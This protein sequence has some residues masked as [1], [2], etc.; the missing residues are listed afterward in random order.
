MR[1]A[2]LASVAVIATAVTYMWLAKSDTALKE[3]TVASAAS[4]SSASKSSN[5]SVSIRKHSVK[6]TKLH[7][8]TAILH[9]INRLLT[10]HNTN[11]CPVDNSDPRASE[12]LRRDMIVQEAQK[13]LDYSQDDDVA[14]MARKLLAYDDGYV[15]EIALKLM[16]TTDID[17]KNLDAMLAALEKSYD[18]KIIRQIMNQM[19]RYSVDNR[20]EAVFETVLT[21]GSIYAGNTVASE[22]L[23]FIQEDNIAYYKELL[24]RLDANTKKAKLLKATLFEYE[25]RHGGG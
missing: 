5:A 24:N 16:A 7:E 6:R 15:Q 22:I 8:K 12:F 18:T 17:E 3:K 10:C 4:F 23:P 2:L 1:K 19:Q 11:S 9:A 13:L 14:A 20:F 25:M 21:H